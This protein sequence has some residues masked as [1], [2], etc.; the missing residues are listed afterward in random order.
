MSFL[1]LMPILSKE[2]LPLVQ[3][4]TLYKVEDRPDMRIPP[5]IYAIA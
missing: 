3:Y 5:S 1:G 4:F 2:V